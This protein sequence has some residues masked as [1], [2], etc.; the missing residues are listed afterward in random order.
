MND[1]ELYVQALQMKYHLVFCFLLQRMTNILYIFPTHNSVSHIPLIINISYVLYVEQIILHPYYYI[2][3]Y[4]Y[5][6]E[7]LKGTTAMKMHPT[8][9]CPYKSIIERTGGRE[10]H[11]VYSEN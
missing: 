2:C 7:N 3:L 6:A 11:L 5:K 9:L 4:F 10:I 8:I 1:L